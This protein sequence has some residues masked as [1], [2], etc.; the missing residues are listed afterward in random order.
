MVNILLFYC[1][2]YHYYYYLSIQLILFLLILVSFSLVQ[3][4]NNYQ[5]WNQLERERL[6]NIFIQNTRPNQCKHQLNTIV[7][8]ERKQKGS[9]KI[10]KVHQ[11]NAFALNHEN[12][13]TTRTPPRHNLTTPQKQLHA[14]HLWDIL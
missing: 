9:F 7:H 13:R 5:T 1:I 10:I 12:S 11:S 4:K 2:Y 14:T 8:V 3:R 6:Y